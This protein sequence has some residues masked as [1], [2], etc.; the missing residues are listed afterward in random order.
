MSDAA[1]MAEFSYY[2]P[3]GRYTVMELHGA[4]R[5]CKELHGAARS[6]TE[7]HRAA[8]SCIELH[9]IQFIYLFK[10]TEIFFYIFSHD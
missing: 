2:V 1:R 10:F 9:R 7:L 8:S 6:C 5:S 4:A 3:E